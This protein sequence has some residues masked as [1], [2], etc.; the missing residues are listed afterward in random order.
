MRME[1]GV[2]EDLVELDGLQKLTTGVCFRITTNKWKVECN[3]PNS[4][5]FHNKIYLLYTNKK[6]NFEDCKMYYL[7]NWDEKK[8]PQGNF[9]PALKM[10]RQVDNVN[11]TYNLLT[12]SFHGLWNLEVH[13]HIHKGFP[14]IPILR[15]IN[16]NP[17]TD[18]HFYKTHCNIMFPSMPRPS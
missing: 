3:E 9:L 11:C 2:S 16:P 18:T 14:I 17:P 8:N 10:L 13:C 7:A 12:H 1:V 15:W 5:T 6:Y 4:C